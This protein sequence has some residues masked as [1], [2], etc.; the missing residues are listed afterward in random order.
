MNNSYLIILGFNSSLP[1]YNYHPTS[2][3]LFIKNNYFLI[4]CGEGTQ[5]QILKSKIKLNK[6]DYILISHLHG[7]HYFGLISILSTYQLLRRQKQ[8]TIYAPRG[9]KQILNI[10]FKWSR[11]KIS[12]PIKFIYL[13]SLKQKKIFENK[14]LK[15]YT[16]PLKHT[17]YTN[18][19]IFK[20]KKK[21]KN[22]NIKNIK[23]IKEIKIKDYL[24][25]KQGYNFKKKNGHI[26]PNNFLTYKSPKPLSYAYCSDTKYYPN[27]IKYI[28]NIDLL[29]HESTYLHKFY[30]YAYLRG[31]S[32]S[33]SAAKIAM[34]SNTKKL[35]LG[36]FSNRY[37]NIN[38]F[39]YEAITIFK[40]TIIPKILKKYYI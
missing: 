40:N 13:T 6:I 22:L 15:I 17:I 14:D 10:N 1:N 29:Y 18:G 21:L 2:Q 24:K 37:I 27:I 31:H 20:E 33:I 30:Y 5:S 3:L 23:M 38:I 19:F 12:Y 16:I 28:K 39:K 9:L 11:T 36:H 4:D 32:T 8:L 35:I 7:D 25:I 34:L 26:I